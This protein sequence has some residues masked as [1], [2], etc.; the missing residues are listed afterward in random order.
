MTRDAYGRSVLNTCAGN[1]TMTFR[2]AGTVLDE[3]NARL[4]LASCRTGRQRQCLRMRYF[5]VDRAAILE[6][7][8]VL[9]TEG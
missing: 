9:R 6:E 1:Q 5:D 4:A 3:V 2:A 7:A 8:L